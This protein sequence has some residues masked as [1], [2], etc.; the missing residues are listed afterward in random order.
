MEEPHEEHMTAVK[1]ILRFITGTRLQG[2]FY[3]REEG[4]ARF[5]GYTYSDLAGDLDIRKST[6]G[7][8]FF[9]GHS[10]VSWQ[11]SKQGW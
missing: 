5:V 11:S 3:P 4:S 2:I 8:L 1:H 6:S 10:P 7:V 9:L